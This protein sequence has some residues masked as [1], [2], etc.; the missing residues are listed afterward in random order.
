VSTRHRL[1]C[2][3]CRFIAKRPANTQ[4]QVKW[5]EGILAAFILCAAAVAG[6]SCLYLLDT[7]TRFEKAKEG[8]VRN[9]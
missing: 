8:G 9:E 1:S 7:P 2:A 6:M 3:C 5:L 4:T